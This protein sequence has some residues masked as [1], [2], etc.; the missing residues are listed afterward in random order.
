LAWERELIGL[1][2][3]EHPLQ[4]YQADLLQVITHTSATLGEA[5]HEERVRVA[6]LVISVRPYQTKAGKPMGFVTL[7]DLQGEIELILFPKTW[8]RYRTLFQEGA[9]LLVDGKVD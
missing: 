6:G 1:Y 9:I 8:E 7:E 2:L 4:P 5:A 3:S